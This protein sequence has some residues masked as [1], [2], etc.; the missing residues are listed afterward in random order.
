VRHV[1]LPGTLDEAGAADHEAALK[2]H[3]RVDKGS[4]VARDENEQIGSV[5]EPVIA[6][7]DPVDRVV[8][9][10]VEKYRPV[11]KPTQQVE[12]I[13]TPLRRQDGL[14]RHC[15]RSLKARSRGSVCN[16]DYL[17]LVG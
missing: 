14:D 3:P 11:G 5:A 2:H 10:V 4:R 12:A 1:D 6:L 13:V 17:I 9:N 8:G 15:V 16:H 7:G